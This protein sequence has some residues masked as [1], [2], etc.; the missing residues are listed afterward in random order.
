[1]TRLTLSVRTSTE[2]ACGALRDAVG[3]LGAAPASRAADDPSPTVWWEGDGRPAAPTA[4][5]CA[6]AG[7][8]FRRR[9]AWGANDEAPPSARDAAYAALG[10]YARAL[11]HDG[12]PLSAALAALGT[13]VDDAAALEAAGLLAP[14]LLAALQRDAAQCCRAAFAAT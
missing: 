5:E 8:R 4:A 13:A 3:A 12:M 9:G 7:D 6:A 10:A 1:M 2:A 11:R 14:A